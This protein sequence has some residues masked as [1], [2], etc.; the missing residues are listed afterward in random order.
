MAVLAERPRPRRVREHPRAGWFAVATVCF[1]A[2]MGQ[3]DASIVTLTF[4]ALQQEFRAPLAAVQWVSLSYLL[5][6]VGLLVVAGRLADATGRKL[7]YVWGF[8]VF[9]AAS[10]A[11][12]LAPGLGWLVVFRLVQAVGA[13]ML[14]A[15]SVALVVGSVPRS[16]MRAALGV[17]AAAQALGLALGPALGGLL[18]DTAGWRWVFLVNLPVGV[19]GLAAGRYLLP[20]T[21]E[22][23]P[24]ARFDFPGLVL[25]AGGS[26][27]LLLALSGVSGLGLPAWVAAVPAAVAVA[28]LTGLVR[29]ER[30]A[31]HPLV[32]LRLLRPRVVSLGLLGALC[33]YLVLFG[34]LTLFPQVL[35]THDGMGPVLTCL[36]A[37][38]AV[39]A[40]LV[41]RL[42]PARLG[43]HGRTV[44]GAVVSAL[45]CG[46]LLLAPGSAPWVAAMLFLLGLGLGVFIPA[47][48]SSIMG[49]IPSQMSA[50]GG[51][52]VNMA[53]GLGSALGIALVTLSLH[54]G[55]ATGPQVAV[56][57][58][59]V[60]G[61]LAVAGA[62]SCAR[63]SA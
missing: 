24:L 62:V 6:L 3:L 26:A 49:G 12:G 51:G 13:A 38:F 22:R 7:M 17:Q 1:G 55:G 14:Q 15:N 2:F 48:N 58:L 44:L 35:G 54:L 9:T 16:R 37:G 61:V 53:R 60:C 8:G 40:V 18:V 32:D 25:L 63:E 30:R 34:P 23:A 27:A 57:A 52:M 43:V 10:V 42:L 20:R 45:G 21:R 33:G 4:P 46:L 39:S 29:W 59:A 41:D 36:P 50:T 28:A 47:N 56:A 19:L 5:A 11:C 31:A